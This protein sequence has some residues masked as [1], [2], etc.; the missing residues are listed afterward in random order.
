MKLCAVLVGLWCLAL[1]P[2]GTEASSVKE[3]VKRDGGVI[4]AA[5]ISAGASLVS[6]DG[7]GGSSTWEL[8]SGQR[9]DANKCWQ[10]GSGPCA[11]G[12]CLDN[13][14]RRGIVIKETT[15]SCKWFC[16]WRA[17]CKTQICCSQ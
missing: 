3:R 5:L 14:G 2:A 9:F 8:P 13:K 6:S 11:N 7:G 17:H 4:T 1:A 12:N 10:D 15:V 16:T